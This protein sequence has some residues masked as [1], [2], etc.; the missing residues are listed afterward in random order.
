LALLVFTI[1]PALAEDTDQG[2][3]ES[4]YAGKPLSYWVKALRDRNE[5]Q[6]L[7]ALEAISFFGPAAQSAVPE[8]I[9]II[10]DPFEPIRLGK[11]TDEV[12]VSKLVEIEIRAEAIAALAEIGEGAAP[13]AVPLIEWAA[14]PRVVPAAKPSALNTDRFI[15][16]AL[17]DAE[18]R[19]HVILAIAFLGDAP[20]PALTE[21]LRSPNAEKRK[22]AVTVLG[23]E[24]MWIAADLIRS[25]DCEEVA[26]A[27]TILEDLA[28]VISMSTLDEFKR[29]PVCMAN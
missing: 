14:R 9:R 27:L 12:I 23:E 10:N 18:H 17:M 26:L 16:L 4:T 6:L 29:M 19:L 8:L 25:G 28:P 21:L 22:L 7:L 2:R 5:D 24:A 15:D 1:A 20:V 3:P 13:A 11:D